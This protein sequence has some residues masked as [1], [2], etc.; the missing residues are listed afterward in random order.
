MQYC[1]LAVA[2]QCCSTA[3]EE[4]LATGRGAAGIGGQDH[5]VGPPFLLASASGGGETENDG[6][7]RSRCW[8]R[9]V[10]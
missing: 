1:E 6:E 4:T 10:R 2:P 8:V 3:V 9:G 5:G 7:V